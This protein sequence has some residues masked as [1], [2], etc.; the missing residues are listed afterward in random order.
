MCMLLCFAVLKRSHRIFLSI[1]K[2][3]C[4]VVAG[5]WN[6]TCPPLPTRGNKFSLICLNFV[7]IILTAFF[8]VASASCFA[9]CR[10]KCTCCFIYYISV[11]LYLYIYINISLPLAPVSIYAL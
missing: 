11:Y 5:R 1:V 3:V 9:E 8:V 2:V 6:A 7:A 10:P 4:D